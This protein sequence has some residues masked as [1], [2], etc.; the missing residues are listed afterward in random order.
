M[1]GARD[2][3]ASEGSGV[4]G[5]SVKK[6]SFPTIEGKR[7]IGGRMSPRRRWQ[8]RQRTVLNTQETNLYFGHNR[9]GVEY[10]KGVTF[11]GVLRKK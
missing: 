1:T 4:G 3:K 2:G 6:P 5:K 10:R 9:V 8:G 11:E 7:K